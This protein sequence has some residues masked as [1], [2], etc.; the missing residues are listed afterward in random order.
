VNDQAIYIRV[1]NSGR[2]GSN[3]G[4]CTL[5][6]GNGP[7]ETTSLEPI[8]EDMKKTV[9]AP[10]ADIII[11]Y[12]SSGLMAKN[13]KKKGLLLQLDNRLATLS[14]DVEESNNPHHQMQIHIPL[15]AM[16][17]FISGRIEDDP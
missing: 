3:L 11:G 9:I 7:I 10:G 12:T 4:G 1:L 14:I 13:I 16:R 17:T 6:F 15:A 8:F 2:K 5:N